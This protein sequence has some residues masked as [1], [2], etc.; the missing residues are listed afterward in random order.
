VLK[1][2]EMVASTCSPLVE[3]LPGHNRDVLVTFVWRAQ[4]HI[5]NV[6]VLGGWHGYHTHD[7]Q[8]HHLADTDVWYR[9]YC[10]RSDTRATYHLLPNDRFSDATWW[11]RM[12]AAQ[13]DPLNPDTLFLPRD[14]ADPD[15]HET[16]LSIFTLPDAP[17]NAWVVPRMDTV[18]GE[19]QTYQFG[20]RILC[21]QRRICVYTPPHYQSIDTLCDLLVLFDGFFF[22]HG[23][24]VNTVLDYLITGRHIP[25]LVA[26]FIDHPDSTTRHHE[27]HGS[28]SFAEFLTKELVPW[29]RQ[30]YHVSV[31]PA[32]TTIG[33]SSHGGLAAAFNA[34]THPAVFGNVLSFSG[35][36][37]WRPEGDEEYEWLARQLAT[38]PRLDLRWY[39]SVGQLETWLGP[40]DGP[41]RVIANRHL[42]NVLQAKGYP[43]HYR[44]VRTGH[45]YLCW[46][47]SL[48]LGLEVLLSMR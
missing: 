21:N 22:H 31:A 11:L 2:W 19:C 39:F 27:L 44:E 20:S 12:R 26:V 1:F 47:D 13:P 32:R 36:F 46:R 43:T 45:D 42:R 48:A 15:D 35:A 8:L 10:M 30:Y 6:L 28:V 24:R 29:A 41:N 9:S 38:H 37:E 14:D 17:T 4:E 25:P 34:F 33:G 18:P 23:L 3:A 40:C 16:I 7:N 5:E